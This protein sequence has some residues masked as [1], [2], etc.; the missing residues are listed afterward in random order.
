MQDR[1]IFPVWDSDA[2]RTIFP[3]IASTVL[4][5]RHS[6]HSEV[7]QCDDEGELITSFTT[8]GEYKWSP[9]FQ[10]RSNRIPWQGF[11]TCPFARKS[12]FWKATAVASRFSASFQPVFWT[13]W[14]PSIRFRR[15]PREDSRGRVRECLRYQNSKQCD[16]GPFIKRNG[17]ENK[18]D[19]PSGII[20]EELSD[21]D[22]SY[23]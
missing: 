22:V 19:L 20:Q 21:L 8:C 11:G 10:L 15:A 4:L 12:V 14:Q 13:L 6:F 5:P 1:F 7:V 2:H 9:F 23:S 3:S 16:G 17:K 18:Q